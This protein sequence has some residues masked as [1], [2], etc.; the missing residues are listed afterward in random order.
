MNESRRVMTVWIGITIAI[1]F[2]L[3]FAVAKLASEC[4]GMGPCKSAP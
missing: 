2:I 1:M 4:A 3:P